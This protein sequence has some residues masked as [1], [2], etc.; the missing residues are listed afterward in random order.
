MSNFLFDYFEQ[1][2]IFFLKNKIYIEF[3]LYL[4]E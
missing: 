4:Y 2:K 3:Y 1:K